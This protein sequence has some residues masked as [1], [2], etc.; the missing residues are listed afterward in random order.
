MDNKAKTGIY[1]WT[2]CISGK[3]YIGSS[4]NLSARFYRYFS[5]AHITVQ[6]KHSLIC[7]AL[8]K[9]GYSMFSL[10]ILEYCSKNE[11]LIREQHYIDLLKPEYNVLK[12]AG[13]P[14]GYKHSE[15]AK[16]KMKGPRPFSPEH[17]S[18]VRKH[19]SKINSKRALSVL[20]TDTKNGNIL[21]Y[22]SI[23]LTARELKCNERTIS[24]YI[25]NKKLYLGRY[26][27]ALKNI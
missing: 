22:E 4:V 7:K 14:V 25:K 5:L 26:S 10:D 9:Y 18:N 15:E 12:K 6:S 19:I 23:R 11:L 17:L 20:V 16:A 27:I 13:S 3:C 8:V 1:R 21:E 24:N 2:N